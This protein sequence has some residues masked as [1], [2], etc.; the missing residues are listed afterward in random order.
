MN[1]I[2]SETDRPNILT[3]RYVSRVF[4]QL[5]RCIRQTISSGAGLRRYLEDCSISFYYIDQTYCRTDGL[6][7]SYDCCFHVKSNS[8][9]LLYS[10]DSQR[11][12]PS[13]VSQS[14]II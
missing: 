6:F 9:L 8:V 10:G 4:I 2:F 7:S 11:F 14:T 1:L 3:E 12:G 5:Y 13:L